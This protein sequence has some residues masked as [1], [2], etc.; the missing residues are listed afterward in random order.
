MSTDSS[1]ESI[2][3]S[4]K[5]LTCVPTKC[6]HIQMHFFKTMCELLLARVNLGEGNHSETLK[7]G[8]SPSAVVLG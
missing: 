7:S 2:C 1:S 8:K 4:Q 3:F 5:V 6:L